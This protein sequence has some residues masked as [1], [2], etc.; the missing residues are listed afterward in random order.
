[1]M[2]GKSSELA[3]KLKVKSVYRKVLAVNSAKDVRYGDDGIIT[4][5]GVVISGIRVE[6]IDEL[7]NKQEYID[8]EV[9]GIDEGQFF[10][11]ID[12]FVIDQLSKTNK[13]FII[14]SLIGDKDKELFGNTYKLMPH[15]E[16][17]SFKHAVCKRCG[18]G[19]PA[20]FTAALVKFSGQEHIGASESY[21]ATCRFHYNRIQL[22]NSNN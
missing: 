11:N 13:T 4:H 6:T 1:M 22:Q 20:S 16:N 10:P 19:T 8:A 15:A 21:E 18:D 17:I 7:L 12:S 2:G 3:R 14:A 5:D 9:V